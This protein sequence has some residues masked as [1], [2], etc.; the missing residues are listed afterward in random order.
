MKKILTLL[1]AS[2]LL[3]ACSKDK[4][5]Y[6][7][8]IATSKISEITDVSAAYIFY[9]ETTPDSTLLNRRNLISTT[10]WLVNIDKRLTLKQVIP[11][12]KTLQEKKQDSKHKNEKAKNYFTCN[13]VSKKTLGFIDFTKTVF[14][15]EPAGEFFTKNQ[16]TTK[17]N[18]FS[19]IFHSLDHIEIMGYADSL[20]NINTSKNDFLNK[21]SAITQNSNNNI[22]LVLN[23]NENL[24]YQNYISI[25]SLLEN[26]SLENVEILENEFIFN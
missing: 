1:F 21:L 24:S 18:R 6:L 16:D 7:P 25:K 20:I 23:F 13:D 3:L 17:N 26:M 9:D 11:H 12:I 5:V 10:N 14:H 8:E 19:V 4:V 22:D 15:T 2:F